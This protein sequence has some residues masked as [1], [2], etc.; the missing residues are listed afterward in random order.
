MVVA[1]SSGRFK[2]NIPKTDVISKSS[3]TP[4][5]IIIY[6]FY[7]GGSLCGFFFTRGPFYKSLNN[8]SKMEYRIKGTPANFVDIE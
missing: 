8:M 3:G 4:H 1:F 6:F 2:F 5:Y 7:T